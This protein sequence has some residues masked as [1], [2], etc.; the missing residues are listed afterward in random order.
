MNR[1]QNHK[2]PIILKIQRLCIPHRPVPP[3]PLRIPIPQIRKPIL[4]LPSRPTVHILQPI[5]LPPR[6][7]YRLREMESRPPVDG[8]DGPVDRAALV[9]APA[10]PDPDGA[11]EVCLDVF[12][13]V[14]VGGCG[15]LHGADG[16]RLQLGEALVD[17]DACNLDAED[18]GAVGDGGVGA[19]ESWGFV[20][21]GL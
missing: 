17:V 15:D 13:V 8:D 11:L 14:A 16:F 6:L 21:D 19:D 5:I 1:R 12:V 20:S 3:L 7:P 2:I 18:E 10:A 9:P 4:A